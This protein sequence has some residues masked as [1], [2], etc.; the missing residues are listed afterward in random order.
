MTHL[1]SWN[2]RLVGGTCAVV[3]GLFIIGGPGSATS[4]ATFE[5]ELSTP[6]EI[7]V[8]VVNYVAVGYSISATE[9]LKGSATSSYTGPAAIEQT[10]QRVA[11]DVASGSVVGAQK[12]AD[13]LTQSTIYHGYQGAP[14]TPALT[15]RIV[16]TITVLQR[17]DDTA[18]ISFGTKNASLGYNYF[19]NVDGYAR[20][21]QTNFNP[22]A[23]RDP[24]P[25]IFDR[26]QVCKYVAGDPS[27]FSDA[28]K[29]A[30]VRMVLFQNPGQAKLNGVESTAAGAFGFLGNN[31]DTQPLFCHGGNPLPVSQASLADATYHVVGYHGVRIDSPYPTGNSVHDFGHHYE[32]V[33]S[34]I[35]GGTFFQALAHRLLEICS[36]TLA[37]P[38]LIQLRRF[39]LEGIKTFRILASESK[40]YGVTP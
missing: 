8:L 9:I 28:S 3:L 19:P 7:P 40:P 6:L 15:F 27:V 34:S 38:Q 39:P 4:A 26:I 36:D 10:G 18:F 21:T 5:D 24:M 2:R 29:V 30:P 23:Y 25:Y 11:G 32:Q 12:T 37:L 20:G 35:M 13:F 17:R 31:P 22:D 14:Q 33:L 1:S 16:E